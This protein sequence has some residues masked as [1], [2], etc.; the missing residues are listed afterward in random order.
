MALK[1]ARAAQIVARALA[2]GEKEHLKLAVA[3]VDAGGNLIAAGRAD[4]SGFASLDAAIGK[5]RLS[6]NIGAPTHAVAHMAGQDPLL[7][8]ALS[9]DGRFTVLAGGFPIMDDKNVEGGFGVAGAH[10]SQ[11]QLIAEAALN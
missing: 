4:D 2:A 6:A 8:A 11:D 1:Y 3:V 7:L 5:A 9:A 10:Y